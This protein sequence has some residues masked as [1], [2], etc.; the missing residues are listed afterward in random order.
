[1]L[2]AVVF[3]LSVIKKQKQEASRILTNLGLKTP[4]SPLSKISLLGDILF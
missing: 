3:V 4:L 1:M 2:Y